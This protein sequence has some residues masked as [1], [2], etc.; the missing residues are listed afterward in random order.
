MFL[1][2]VV[3]N[4]S[5]DVK[6]RISLASAAFG[7]LKI[8]IWLKREISKPLK[9]KLYKALILTIATYAAETCTI[10]FEDSRKF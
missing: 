8:P 3:P 2:S 5:D 1:E 9:V 7:R 10:Q 6:R 4:S